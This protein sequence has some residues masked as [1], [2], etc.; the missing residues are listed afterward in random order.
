M[1][2]LP[3]RILSEVTAIL[4]DGVVEVG[5]READ[6]LV[7]AAGSEQ[8]AISFALRR[9][10]GE[11]LQYVIG[12]AP[13]R[14]IELMVGPGVL[15][16]R[17]E[18]EV[19]VERALARLPDRGT[20]LDV[21]TGSGAIALAV[22]AERPDARVIATDIAEEALAWFHVNEDALGLDIELH[23]SDLFAGLP[24]S[25]VGELDVVVSNPPYVASSDA[26]SLPV[27]VVEHEPHVAL[28]AGEDGLATIRDLVS[29]APRWLKRGGWLVME[30]GE[31]QAAEVRALLEGA[32]YRDVAIHPDMTGRPRIAEGTVGS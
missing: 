15:I 8:E 11:P 31:T 12:T 13:F 7:D 3:D 1:A 19:V 29:E 28:F 16:P 9:A 18:T 5:S 30:I 2:Q 26:D 14:Q 25:L 17:P 20:L 6:W 10:A 22:K 23:R 21:G 24:E 4:K 32:G 27:D